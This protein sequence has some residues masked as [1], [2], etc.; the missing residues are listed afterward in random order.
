MIE[1]VN[2]DERYIKEEEISLG[3]E[4]NQQKYFKALLGTFSDELSNMESFIDVGC[5]EGFLM[6]EMSEKTDIS[7]ISGLDYFTWGKEICPA[8]LRGSYHKWD[9]RDSLEEA[10]WMNKKYDIVNCTE[11]AEHIDPAYCDVFM[12]N[13]EMM[14][15]EYLIISWSPDATNDP[16]HQH[17]NPLGIEEFHAKMEEYGF[18]RNDRLTARLVTEGRN[19]GIPFWY[20]TNGISVWEVEE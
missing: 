20:L 13:L 6:K 14:T 7:S 10:D 11:V 4:G 1:K 3:H 9:L 19:H 5:R 8:E 12:K 2:I 18:V 16:N 17:L 15:G